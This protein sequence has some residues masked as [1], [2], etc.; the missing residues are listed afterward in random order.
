[1]AVTY[2][3]RAPKSA[4]TGEEDV[5]ARVETMLRELEE[6]REAK[7]RDYAR[8]FDGWDGDIVVPEDAM[9]AAA[10]RVPQQLKDD[11]RFAIERVRGFAEAQLKSLGEFEVEL[12]PGLH[13]GQRL[14]PVTTAGCYVPGGRYAHVASA[15]MSVTTARVAGVPNVIACS[16]ARK[17]E[18]VNPAILYTLQQ[19][20]ADAVLALGGV[21]G[22]AALAFGLFTGHAADILVGPGNQYVAEA[23]RLL[24]GRVGIDLFAGPTEILVIADESADPRI[25][26]TDLVGQA[27][28][29]PN[30]PAWLVTTSRHLAEETMRCIP[31]LIAALPEPN[32][33]AALAA[34]RDY[35]EVVL[36]DS[37]E[38]A[39][40]ASD[41]YAPEH[42]EVHAADLDWWLQ[43]L[44]NYG[45]LFLGEETTVA[46]GDKVSG[47]N[48]ILPTKGAGR[49]T[50]GLSVGK[51]IKT[52]TYQRM[53]RAA[54]RDVGATTARISRL[55][56]MEAHARTADE[57]LL[58]YFP[59]E[60]F[61]LAG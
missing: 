18:G 28:H 44:R 39:A 11:I 12:S 35:G 2:I 5:R 52:V 57:R 15:V 26:A 61:D 24:F 55:E 6:G 14:I 42:L 3:K 19:A 54:N 34:W 16:P 46:Y 30:S 31:P 20:G 58:K 21:Q 51:F 1:M 17:G 25:V 45:S 7:A 23:K 38:E 13:A 41:R 47:P 4:A 32:R 48:H 29:G 56:G 59:G 50:G 37:R 33:A 60:R 40:A 43:R 10:K 49:Y 8:D 53:S 36:A 22:I 9:A 27:E